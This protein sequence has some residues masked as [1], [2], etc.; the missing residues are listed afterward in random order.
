VGKQEQSAKHSR[1]DLSFA[2]NRRQFFRALFQEAAVV[3]GSL[4]GRP[5]YRL[6]ELGRLPDHQ[7]AQVK[8]V[9][10][11]DYE[12]FVDQGYVRARYE[13]KEQAPLKLFSMEEKES[14][15]AFNLFDGRH[16]LGE[17]GRHLAQEMEWDEGRAFAHARDLFL[18]LVEP[19]VCVPRDPLEP[20]G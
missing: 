19:M 6:S 8:P 16:S 9:V 10:N 7:L 5:G 3:R 11:Q 17:I 14:R 15:V 1:Q 13:I 18:S 2:C 4:Q 20:G 12:I